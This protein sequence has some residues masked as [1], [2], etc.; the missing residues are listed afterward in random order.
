MFVCM[1]RCGRSNSC[2]YKFL[3][4]IYYVLVYKIKNFIFSVTISSVIL[5]QYNKMFQYKVGSGAALNVK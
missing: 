5:F 4:R 2:A 1:Q 3:S